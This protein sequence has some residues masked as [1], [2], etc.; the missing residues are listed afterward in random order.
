MISKITLRNK[1]CS[2]QYRLGLFPLIHPERSV[3]MDLVMGHRCDDPLLD[4]VQEKALVTG[5]SVHVMVDPVSSKSVRISDA[6]R[7]KLEALQPRH[8]SH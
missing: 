6:W 4:Q 5:S 3:L 8:F 7:D 2:V 1:S